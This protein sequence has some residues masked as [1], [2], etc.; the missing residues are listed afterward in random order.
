MAFIRRIDRS[1]VVV[2]S[3]LP[4]GHFTAMNLLGI[5]FYR[6]R[7]FGQTTP[8]HLQEVL[9]HE[10]IH[11]HQMRELAYIGFY[12]LYTAE[13]LWRLFQFKGR[14]MQA[15][16]AIRFE[17]EAYTHQ[18]DRHYLSRRRLFAWHRRRS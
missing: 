8:K 5:V 13:F 6:R 4:L 7:A 2:N 18:A 10:A 17:Q 3:I 16:R 15:Y 14:W 11:T 12:L 1:I 9:N